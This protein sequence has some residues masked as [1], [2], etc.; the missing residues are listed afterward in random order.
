[1]NIYAITIPIV[2][3][4]ST[5]TFLTVA[6]YLL[7]SS[8]HR[9]RMELMERNLDA[10]VFTPQKNENRSL[11][12]G[13]LFTMIGIGLIL[14]DVMERLS[15]LQEDIAYFAM[16]FLMGGLGLLTCHTYVSKKKPEDEI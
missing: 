8:R 13:L 2:A 4:I 1:M 9:E 14:G 11:K 6:F 16:I 10:S 5:F 7:I 3:I 15:L 12:N